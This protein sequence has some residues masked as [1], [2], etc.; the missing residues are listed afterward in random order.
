MG[1]LL[2]SEESSKEEAVHPFGAPVAAPLASHRGPLLRYCGNRDDLAARG[3]I[4]QPPRDS[5]RC[6]GKALHKE[7]RIRDPVSFKF[8]LY[9]ASLEEKIVAGS[10]AKRSR[11]EA[12]QGRG[13][14]GAL[15]W[16]SAPA[17]AGSCEHLSGRSWL[18]WGEGH[19]R[20]LALWVPTQAASPTFC[21]KLLFIV[22][23]WLGNSGV[24]CV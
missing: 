19:S 11:V 9:L 10:P 1:G 14:A 18:M 8:W 7:V 13:G 22:C 2:R 16:V 21:C 15:I 24:S 20:S 5:A 23:H 4:T 12:G 17:E 3:I 6:S